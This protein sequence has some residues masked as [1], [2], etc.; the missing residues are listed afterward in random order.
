MLYIDTSYCTTYNGSNTNVGDILTPYIFNYYDIKTVYTSK[1]PELYA[2]G[3]LFDGIPNNYTGN[4]WSTGYLMRPIDK[5]NLIRAPYAVRGKYTLSCISYNNTPVAMGDGGLLL[6]KL[7]KPKIQKKYNLGIIFHYVDL[8]WN[9]FD[10]KNFSLFSRPDVLFIDVKD[11]PET[12]I[13]KL[14]SC[15]NI[16][17]SSLHGLITSDSYGINNGI[18]TTV[19]S[20][21]SLHYNKGSYKFKDYY[22]AFNQP[23]PEI[24]DLK[25]ETTIEECLSH[26][27]EFNKFNIE[28]LKYY[29]DKSLLQLK[30]DNTP[31]E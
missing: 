29:L 31:K 21:K 17:S 4:I 26:C 6:E 7:Y 20:Q 16:L 11:N 1:N 23:L 27:K 19:A 15:N 25:N 14:T 2:I 3:S 5:K 28:P 8:D 9:K 10:V 24:L 22:S 30:E 18:I 12:F 13:D